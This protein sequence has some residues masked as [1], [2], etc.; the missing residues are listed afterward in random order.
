MSYPPSNPNPNLLI[1]EGH[2]DRMSVIGLMAHHVY[3]PDG[4][5]NAPVFI[6]LGLSADEILN[7]KYLSTQVKKPGLKRIGV[8]FDADIKLR[9]RYERLRTMCLPHFPALPE[10]MPA[11]GVIVEHQGIRFGVWIMPDNKSAGDLETFLRY[12]VPNTG[13][14]TWKHAEQSV[15]HARSIGAKC[16]DAHVAKANLYTWLAWQDEPGQSPGRSLTQKILDPHGEGAATF[17][18]WFRSLYEL[19]VQSR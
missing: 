14:A 1:V 5:E 18:N 7:P 6:D 2:D 16:K 11:E 19:K 15:A 3:W 8:L 12:L 4:K 9:M 10:E 17:I 13:E